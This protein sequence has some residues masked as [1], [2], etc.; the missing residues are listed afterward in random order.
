MIYWY[1]WR[2]G[3]QDEFKGLILYVA[4]GERIKTDVMDTKVVRYMFKDQINKI[5]KIKINNR[6]NFRKRIEDER[7]VFRIQKF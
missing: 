7:K 3:I 4:V 2:I 6:W 1:T 5:I